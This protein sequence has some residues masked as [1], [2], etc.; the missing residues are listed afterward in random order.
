[1]TTYEYLSVNFLLNDIQSGFRSGDSAINQLLAI[2]HNIYSGFDQVPYRDAGAVFS[3]LP[4]AVDKLWYAGLFYKLE[5]NSMSCNL[6]SLSSSF[7]SQRRQCVIL[8]GNI[9]HGARSPLEC[10]RAQC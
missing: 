3:D 9:P 1:M 5:S 7:L 10:P 6:L 8:K 2:T 4:N